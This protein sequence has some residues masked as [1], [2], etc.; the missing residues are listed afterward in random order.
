MT[1]SSDIDRV[2]KCVVDTLVSETE[3]TSKLLNCLNAKFRF[4]MD[5]A[6]VIDI[7]DLESLRKLCADFAATYEGDTDDSCLTQEMID[8]RMAL[9]NRH[10]ARADK[11]QTPQ[12]LL[13]ATIE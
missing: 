2:L 13:N 1:A 3:T 5:V 11:P 7:D 9:R 8:Y 10:F 6:A 12:Q 4:L